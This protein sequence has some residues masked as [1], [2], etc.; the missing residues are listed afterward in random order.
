METVES[1]EKREK[2]IIDQIEDE[3]YTSYSRLS[4]FFRCA[5]ENLDIDNDFYESREDK[6]NF[7]SFVIEFYISTDEDA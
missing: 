2:N 7:I 4:N 6:F 3:E 5:F 1:L